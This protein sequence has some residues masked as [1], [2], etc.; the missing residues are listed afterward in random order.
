MKHN[1]QVYIND[2]LIDIDENTAM[3]VNFEGFSTESLGKIYLSHTNTFS[4]PLTNH[5]RKALGFVDNM[6]MN[7]KLVQGSWYGDESFK[8]YTDGLLVF[9]GK[10]YVDEINNGHINLFIIRDKDLMDVLKQYTM[11][12]AT[13]AIVPIINAELDTQFSAGATW[14]N[15]VG[16]MVSGE[17]AV[18]L[19]YSVGTL[20]KQYPYNKFNTDT[21]TY[22][23]GNKYDDTDNNNNKERYNLNS[24]NVLTT[25]VITNDDVVGDYKTGCIYVRLYNLI[26]TVLGNLGF[27]VSFDYN[28]YLTL[29]RQ[30]IRMPDIVTYMGLTTYKFSFAAND[31]YHYSRY[32]YSFAHIEDYQMISTPLHIWIQ[33]R[34]K[35]S[36]GCSQHSLPNQTWIG[37]PFVMRKVPVSRRHPLLRSL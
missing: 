23:C 6:N 20:S 14:D 10:V 17:N 31:N 32:L 4:I 36:S 5:N 35:Q 33:S 29:S 22:S 37:I 1:V 25:E 16:Y 13:Q 24:E 7:T 2:I 3:G 9:T 15:I 30:F 11:W 19:P 26:T 34:Q 21:Q 18:W 8:M 28:V 27:D 12:D